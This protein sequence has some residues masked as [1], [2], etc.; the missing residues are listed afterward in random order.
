M[1]ASFVTGVP[2]EMPAQQLDASDQVAFIEAGVPGVQFFAGSSPDYH[3]PS[4][5]ADKV[6]KTIRTVMTRMHAEINRSINFYRSQQSGAAPG[7]VLCATPPELL[8]R[9]LAFDLPPLPF[10]CYARGYDA[11]LARA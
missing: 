7:V 10:P 2:T 3:K 11:E 9:R 5:T 1:G 4:D 8:C 6:S